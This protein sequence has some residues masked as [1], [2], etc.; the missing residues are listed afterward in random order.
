M[1]VYIYMHT[2]HVQ[3][4]NNTVTVFFFEIRSLRLKRDGIY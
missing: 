1:Y 3:S 4:E 2:S